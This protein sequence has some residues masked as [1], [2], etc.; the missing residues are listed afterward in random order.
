MLV[1]FCTR[2]KSV[3]TVMLTDLLSCHNGGNIMLCELAVTP[4]QATPATCDNQDLCQPVIARVLTIVY[5]LA[6]DAICCDIVLMS[7][8]HCGAAGALVYLKGG[9]SPAT[10]LPIGKLGEQ[11]ELL[12]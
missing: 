10:S 6:G 8:I 1:L 5:L 2:E 4:E 7:A 11:H 12:S 9:S 3:S